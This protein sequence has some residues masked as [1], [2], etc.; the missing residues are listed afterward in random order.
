LVLKSFFQD[1][2]QQVRAFRLFRNSKLFDDIMSHHF[3]PGA[4]YD[5]CHHGISLLAVSM[6]TFEAQERERQDD[7]DFDQA[8][9]KTPEAVRKHNSKGPPPLPSSIGD[10]LQALWRLIVLTKGLFT[11]QCSLVCQL[12]DLYDALQDKEQRIMS[13]ATAHT[14]LIPQLVWAITDKSREFYSQICKRNDV[15]PPD[16]GT[17]PKFAIADISIYTSMFRAG[18][19][20]EVDNMPE[21]WKRKKPA[22]ESGIFQQQTGGRYN[23]GDPDRRR[24]NNPFWPAETAEELV[25]P[26][27]PK[28]FAASG[29]LQKLKKRKPGVTLTLICQA[30][31]LRRG[32]RDLDRSGLPRK[33][34]LNYVCMGKCRRSNK[35][36]FEHP[37]S[38]EEAAAVAMYKQLE[39]GIRKL[40]EGDNTQNGN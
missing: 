1:L 27:P 9:H 30:A 13:N 34:C 15:D 36:D 8:T 32:T 11:Q 22:S 2:G 16:D 12:E 5:T 4:Y 17:P 20:I 33:A 3:E 19:P 38:V 24:G 39:P 28:A 23:K 6:R 31:G 35:C 10:L 25:N 21:Q 7:E 14:T 29:E 18:L 40:L 37:T 26:S